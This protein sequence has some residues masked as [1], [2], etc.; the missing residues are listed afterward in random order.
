MM[1]H[2]LVCS[3]QRGAVVSLPAV[4]V[5]VLLQSPFSRESFLTDVTLKWFLSGVRPHVLAQPGGSGET[6]ATDITGELRRVLVEL[7]VV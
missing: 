5:L 6:L 4:D 3:R 7:L 1:L 2:L